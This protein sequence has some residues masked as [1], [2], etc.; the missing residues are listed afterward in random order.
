MAKPKKKSRARAS[1]LL[2]RRER[3]E[4]NLEN[5]NLHHLNPT[6]RIPRLVAE[7]KID[8][9]AILEK[10]GLSEEELLDKIWATKIVNCRIHDAWHTLFSNMFAWEAVKQI[11]LWANAELTDFAIG[12]R[13]DQRGA[14][15]TLFGSYRSPR[16]AIEVIKSDWWPEYPP[17]KDKLEGDA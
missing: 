16:E 14:W 13:N 4:K 15:N 2:K 7:L 9:A 6:S 8:Q 1:E 3:R 10:I 5:C 17:P 12:L 11:K